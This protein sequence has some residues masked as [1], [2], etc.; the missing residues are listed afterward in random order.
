[1]K[2]DR[3]DMSADDNMIIMIVPIHCITVKTTQVLIQDSFGQREL[4][5]AYIE[6]P[7]STIKI[8]AAI[9]VPE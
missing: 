3:H 2:N 1:M 4:P 6:L 8:N 5:N 7:N 9:S